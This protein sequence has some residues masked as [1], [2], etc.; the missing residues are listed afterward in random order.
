MAHS[1]GHTKRLGN[2]LLRLLILPCVAIL[3]SGC[4]QKMLQLPMPN[5]VA[6]TVKFHWIDA[7]ESKPEGMM[8]FLYP[9]GEN[10]GN[11]WMFVMGLD[12]GVINVAPGEYHVVAHNNDTAA[13]LFSDSDIYDAYKCTTRN[14]TVY[15][16]LSASRSTSGDNVRIQP[17]PMWTTD[18][19]TVTIANNDTIYLPISQATCHY[20]CDISNVKNMGSV[21]RMCGTVSGLASEFSFCANAA[22][23]T[24]ATV[25][26]AFAAVSDNQIGSSLTCFG[27]L[28]IPGVPCIMRL[29]A[30]LQDGNKIEYDFNVTDIV[31]DAPD[32]KNVHIHIDG[33]EF[34]EVEAPNPDNPEAGGGLDVDVDNWIVV[35]IDLT[36]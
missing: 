13:Q 19:P 17:D 14:C 12:G 20:T 1:R 36:N 28:D 4:K 18:I 22:Y 31:D 33:F 24:V 10:A 15:E 23:G 29:Y 30:W 6:A 25:P 34:P 7:Y 35:D 11:P 9:T 27:R 32:P 8:L 16:Y 5:G 21:A 2:I 26:C 3:L